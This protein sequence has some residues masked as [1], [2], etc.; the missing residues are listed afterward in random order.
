[1]G[2]IGYC[3]LEF[4]AAGQAMRRGEVWKWR[5]EVEPDNIH[6]FIAEHLPKVY[7]DQAQRI[8]ERK[9]N[10]ANENEAKYWANI[11]RTFRQYMSKL[12]R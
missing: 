9:D 8:R 7:L 2:R 4:V 3:W 10:A 12:S 11:E 6:L 5:K 1:T